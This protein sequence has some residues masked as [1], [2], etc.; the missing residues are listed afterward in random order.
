MKGGT[1]AGVKRGG[2]VSNRQ[3]SHRY[4]KLNTQIVGVS[5]DP[6]EKNAQFW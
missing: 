3:S 2:K 5:V 1:C 4:R 6:P